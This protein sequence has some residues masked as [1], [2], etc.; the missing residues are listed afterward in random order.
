MGR[1]AVRSARHPGLAAR[2][3]R[4]VED[5]AAAGYASV[6][7][8]QLDIGGGGNERLCRSRRIGLPWTGEAWAPGE[9][10]LGRLGPVTLIAGQGEPGDISLQS[11]FLDRPTEHR[12]VVASFRAEIP[13]AVQQEP[14]KPLPASWDPANPDTPGR[15]SDERIRH[16]LRAV[17]EIFWV[18]TADGRAVEMPDWCAYTGQSPAETRDWGWLEAVHPADR[19]ATAS[20][21]SRA[22]ESGGESPYDVEYR[23]RGADGAY[24]WF[25]AR[26]IPIREPDGSIREWVGACLDIDARRVR[27]E[28]S[29]RESERRF[30]ATFEQA[31]VGI[32]HVGLDGRWLRVNQALCDILGYPR[33][34]L[35]GLTFQEITHPDDLDADLILADRLARGEVDRYTLE[36]RYVR[37]DGSHVWAAL[38]GSVVRTTEG[39]PDYFIA[40]VEDI[41]QRKELE[42]RLKGAEQHLRA[43]MDSMFAFVGVLTPDGDLIEA[44]RAALEA[45]ALQ[46]EDVLHRPFEEAYWWAYDPAVQRELREAIDRAAAGQPSRYDVLIRLAPD[47]FEPI[48][49]MIAPLRNEEGRITHLVPSAMIITQRVEAEAAL[50][51]S[52]AR[53]RTLADNIPQLAWMADATGSIFWYNRR[54]LDYTGATLEAMHGWGWQAV[55]H[56][57]WVAP[58]TERFRT[59]IDRG[60]PWEDTF[61]LR[62][63]DG[64]YRW[65]LSR[66]LPIKDSGGRVQRWF[67]TNTDVT[68]QR[69]EA[70][71]RERLY[72]D[73][74]AA[75]EAKSEFMATMSHEL[76]TP[77][78]AIIGYADLLEMGVPGTLPG[79]ARQY[80]QRIRLAATH[81]KQLI[82]DVL[83]FNRL[84]AGQEQT[85]PQIVNICDLVRELT[86]VI[87][88]LAEA[89][90]LRLEVPRGSPP[91]QVHADARKLRQ[92]LVNLLGN[93]VKFTPVGAVSLRIEETGDTVRFEVGDTGI[94]LHQDQLEVAFDPFWQADRSLTRTSE[95]S[96]LG[97]AISRRF[98]RS[99]GGD[100]LVSSEPG[101]GSTF[102]LVLPRPVGS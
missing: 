73:A 47:R 11:R 87:S 22:V 83:M 97:L 72:R 68:Q 44:N 10:R 45:A 52:E 59:A 95:G 28:R 16:L 94:G 15:Q 77:L 23:V 8:R 39:A 53:F 54:W 60:E 50:R 4:R 42:S 64:A 56:P 99:L 81:Q 75:S 6:H 20:A 43:V 57:D 70:A 5:P 67:G 61:P 30:R 88:P 24:R 84:E 51:E 13:Y 86:A 49:F 48:D 31:A 14:L 1:G 46:P 34:E 37:G 41:S 69:E 91:A 26:G 9:P 3:R 74:Q 96:G 38:T 85:E 102:T 101:H 12:R 71:E 66:A 25:S 89:K 82:E 78:N 80:V 19:Q 7:D 35:S 98:A 21:W 29:L 2:G 36:K 90:G 27:A 93:A 18:A 76:R 65:F 40:V 33:D 17:V 62:G 92:I 79:D 55:H 63:A 100:I 58:V 32:A